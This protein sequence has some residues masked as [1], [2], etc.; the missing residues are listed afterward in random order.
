MSVNPVIGEEKMNDL[1]SEYWPVQPEPGSVAD[2]LIKQGEARGEVRG[3]ARGEARGEEKGEKKASVRTIWILQSILGI[4]ESSDD[5]FADKSLNELQVMIES[6]R[7]QIVS[8][9]PQ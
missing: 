6:L 4:P 1:A 2:Q 7:A 9:P 8:R 5:E 3:E